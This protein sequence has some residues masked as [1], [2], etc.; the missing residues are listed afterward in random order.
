MTW[1]H[2]LRTLRFRR[3]TVPPIS[4]RNLTRYSELHAQDVPDGTR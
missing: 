1:R 3:I 2:L 4:R